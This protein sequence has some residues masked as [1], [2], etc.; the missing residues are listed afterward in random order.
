MINNRYKYFGFNQ[1]QLFFCVSTYPTHS[2]I[3]RSSTNIFIFIYTQSN[4][5]SIT[6]RT[7]I[8]IIIFICTCGT[9]TT[10]TTGTSTFAISLI[11]K[12]AY[13]VFYSQSIRMMI[14]S[15]TFYLFSI[16]LSGFVIEILRG[17]S[18]A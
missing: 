15:S 17:L 16:S 13:T 6:I 14:C 4:S 10:T 11:T 7:I 5:I 3:I 9:S 18:I 8:S 1:L 2:S 12:L